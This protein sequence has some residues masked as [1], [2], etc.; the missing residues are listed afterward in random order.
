M[1][2]YPQGTT[3][4]GPATLTPDVSVLTIT[5]DRTNWTDPTI[6]V[7]IRGEISLDGGATWSPQPSGQAVWPWGAFPIDFTAAG[8][9][10]TGPGGVVVNTSELTVSI[11][12]V[13]NANRQL[14]GSMTI[15][16]G[17]LRTSISVTIS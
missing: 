6:T 14:R 17:N 1:K 7:E 12:D 13:G 5:L 15:T 9:V 11:P 2:T 8:G 10:I 16:G 3:N 4:Y